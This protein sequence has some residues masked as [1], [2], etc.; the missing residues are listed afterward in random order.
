MVHTVGRIHLH[1]RLSP[2][3]TGCLLTSLALT[4]TEFGQCLE[5]P[6]TADESISL[7]PAA[8][9]SLLNI[10]AMMGVSRRPV[11]PDLYKGVSPKGI[12]P[13]D[14]TKLLSIYT[15][16]SS[17]SYL[18]HSPF[19]THPLPLHTYLIIITSSNTL[20]SAPIEVCCST[21][22]VPRGSVL[23]RAA[24]LLYASSVPVY[25]D[26]RVL[27]LS[28]SVPCLPLL[29]LF[30]VS[31]PTIQPHQQFNLPQLS[32]SSFKFST[33]QGFDAAHSATA[34]KTSC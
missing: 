5:L 1:I 26:V 10:V 7:R 9:P 21:C 19:Q 33:L 17:S 13:Q 2:P 8:V 11:T 25:D 3:I 18:L 28:L 4:I 34:R 14:L 30:Y 24:R 27:D 15:E 23:V 22:L 6:A 29:L 16:L 32:V 12:T 20:C 31:K